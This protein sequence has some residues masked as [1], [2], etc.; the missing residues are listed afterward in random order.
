[1]HS[2]VSLR[3]YEAYIQFLTDGWPGWTAPLTKRGAQNRATT[4]AAAAVGLATDLPDPRRQGET[5]GHETAAW[6]QLQETSAWLESIVPQSR[7]DAY[8]MYVL[9]RQLLRKVSCPMLFIAWL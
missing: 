7:L 9:C 2:F 3:R 6:E 1:M 4:P 8:P 5:A